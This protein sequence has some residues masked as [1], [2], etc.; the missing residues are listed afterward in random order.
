MFAAL[1][2]HAWPQDQSQTKPPDLSGDWSIDI[3]HSNY[4]RMPVPKRYVETIEQKGAALSITSVSE[5]RNGSARGC[6]KLTTDDRDNVNEVNGNDFHS[7]SHW[8]ATKLIT[9]I[10]G[11]KG[12]RMIE[13]RWLSAGG[14]TQTVETYL[15]EMRGTPQMVR[16]MERTR[17]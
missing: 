8:D 4:G 2:A 3:A 11:D 7:K 12:L 6:L 16:V 15:G 13:V 14:K 9:T 17:N 10:T 5:D 1:T